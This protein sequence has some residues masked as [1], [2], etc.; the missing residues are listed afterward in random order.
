MRSTQG[1]GPSNSWAAVAARVRPTWPLRWREQGP[2]TSFE[3]SLGPREP[4]S[5]ATEPRAAPYEVAHL[6]GNLRRDG[7]PPP[8]APCH[9]AIKAVDTIVQRYANLLP[10]EFEIKLKGTRE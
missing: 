3:T 6:P 8:P 1:R 5:L 9:E 10:C 4:G 2:K 7:A